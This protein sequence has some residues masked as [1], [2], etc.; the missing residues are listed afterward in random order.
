M[1]HWTL[2]LLFLVGQ[3]AYI[4]TRMAKAIR[5]PQHPVA[6]RGAFL[7]LYW[8][9]LLIRT[10][11][12]SVLFWIWAAYPGMIPGLLNWFGISLSFDLPVATQPPIALVA[13]LVADFVLELIT[14]RVPMLRKELPDIEEEEKADAAKV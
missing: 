6:S 5:D 8:D 14:S 10:F 4:F 13:G 2:W 1:L 12:A 9:I 11:A 7:A 3:A